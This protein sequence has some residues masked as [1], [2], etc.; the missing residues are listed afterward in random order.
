M[1]VVKKPG[2]DLEFEL[3]E[4]Y[5][6]TGFAQG[7]AQTISSKYYLTSVVEYAHTMMSR[8]FNDTMSAISQNKPW[9]FQHVYEP[10]QVGVQ[11][12]Q[13]WENKLYGR[14]E[15][16][17]ASFTWKMSHM[18]ILTPEERLDDPKDPINAAA[19]EL[20]DEAWMK[21]NEKHY[22][23]R[24]RAPIM[25]YGLRTDIKPRPGTKM[26]FIPTW[27]KQFHYTGS[28]RTGTIKATPKN[29]MFSKHNVPDFNYHN[30]QEPS[31]KGGTVGQFTAQWVA[32]WSGGGATASFNSHVRGALEGGLGEW[33]KQ[34]GRSMSG[35]RTRKGVAS[36]KTFN[37]KKAAFE[38]GRNLAKAFVEGKARSYKSASKYIDD[39]G[40]F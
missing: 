27:K 3:E 20:S 25:E 37:N 21:L 40:V 2:I 12:M 19:D 13:L 6:A 1:G 14:G 28:R 29:F 39:Y 17:Q 22:V 32:F 30:P 9:A 11:S 5:F 16:R 33:E 15:K 26:L 8:D 35:S 24:M 31:V 7:L 36:F 38:S 34:F 10:G 23:F 4:G 18:P